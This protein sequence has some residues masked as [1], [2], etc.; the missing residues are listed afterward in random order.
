MRDVE[1]RYSGFGKREIV[2]R[3]ESSFRAPLRQK[4]EKLLAVGYHRLCEQAHLVDLDAVN[5]TVVPS[6]IAMPSGGYRRVQTAEGS[7]SGDER[8]TRSERIAD[9]LYAR[10][11]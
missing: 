10:K 8:R 4:D 3:S 11:F 9:K 7:T 6:A 2:D 1:T 5:T